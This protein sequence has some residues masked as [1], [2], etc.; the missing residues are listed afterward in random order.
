MLTDQQRA[1]IVRDGYTV[2]PQA[3]PRARVEAVLTAINTRLGEGLSPDDIARMQAGGFAP[4]LARS[5]EVLDLLFATPAWAAAEELIGAGQVRRPDR[6]QLALRFPGSNYVPTNPIHI[7]GFSD[8]RNGIA[9]DS[10]FRFTLLV[11]VLLSDVVA[12]E[13]GNFTVWPGTH[14]KLEEHFRAVGPETVARGMPDIDYGDGVQ[15]LGRA[16]DILLAHYQLA[17]G[18]TPNQGPHI[19]YAAFFRLTHVAHDP[20]DLSPMTD[21]WREWP[22]LADL[23]VAAP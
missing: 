23:V 16:G 1:D 20:A 7:D 18:F 5:P 12:T 2:L 8:G 13:S 22:G 3:V 17:H 4:D 21:I 6:A 11:Q 19:R 9:A 14:H 15:L 10:V